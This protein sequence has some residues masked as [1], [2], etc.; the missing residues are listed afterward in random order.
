MVFDGSPANPLSGPR[1]FSPAGNHGTSYLLLAAD[2]SAAE[3]SAALATA[4][5]GGETVPA[6]A[7]SLL[8][9]LE[10]RE[11]DLNIWLAIAVVFFLA[12]WIAGGIHGRRRERMRRTRLRF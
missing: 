8:Q 12:G 1:G 2:A 10:G 11:G 9:R 3:K 4:A 6:K 5:D 7:P